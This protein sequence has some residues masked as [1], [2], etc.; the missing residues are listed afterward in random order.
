MKL[1]QAKIDKG[2]PPGRYHDGRGAGLF[3]LVKPSGRASF[4][5]RMM[6]KGRRKDVGLGSV[7]DWRLAEVREKAESNRRALRRGEEISLPRKRFGA[8]PNLRA[9]VDKV[10]DVRRPE[11]KAGSRVEEQWRNGFRDHVFPRFGSRGIET[12]TPADMVDLYAKLAGKPSVVKAL[13]TRLKVVFEYAIANG[14]RTDNPAMIARAALPKTTG[15]GGHHDAIPHAEL[16]AVLRKVRKHKTTAARL[17]LEFQALTASRPNEALGAR[18]PEIDVAT[19]TWTIPA[20]RMKA[21][22]AHRVAL[23]PSAM[24]VLNEAKNLL[25]GDDLI[26]PSARGSE[27]ATARLGDVLRAIKVEGTAHG[28]RSSFRDW[29]AETGVDREV[30]E[31]CLAHT[32]PSQTEA[33]YVRTDLLDR[34]VPVMQEWGEYLTGRKWFPE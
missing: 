23:S 3:L 33:P 25:Q 4:V 12:I 34:R 1:T 28:L 20:E 2:L 15:K 9:V 11:W 8:A 24:S 5:Q 30:A 26:F 18:W 29:C 17:A 19:S 7:R 6:I 31:S 14:W 21:K 10:I 16:G 22:R 27:M 13:R 32:I